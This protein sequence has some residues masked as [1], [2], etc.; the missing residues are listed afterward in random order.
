MH[1]AAVAVDVVV[2]VPGEKIKVIHVLAIITTKPGK[3]DEVLEGDPMVR[4][5]VELFEARPLHVDYDDD[6]PRPP[7]P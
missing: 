7:A 4:K 5:V 2:E 1:L 3:R 6:T